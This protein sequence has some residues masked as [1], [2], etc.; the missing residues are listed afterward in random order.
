MSHS[1]INTRAFTLVE[2]IVVVGIITV[3]SAI[4]FQ[5]GNKFNDTIA[6]QSV[7]QDVS[8]A[9]REAQVNGTSVRDTTNTGNFTAGSGIVFDVSNPGYI[10]VFNDANG[11]GVYDGGTA[12]DGT[13]ECVDKIVLRSGVKILSVCGYN[14][15]PTPVCS[16]TFRTLQA[17][18]IRPSLSDTITITTTSGGFGAGGPW[19]GG[20]L[21]L[22]TPGGAQKMINIFTTGGV[23]IL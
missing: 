12:C 21:I 23:V 15:T 9:L 4:V 1:N 11:N 7:A 5:N 22:V 17:L 3:I 20:Q 8:L 14:G 10:M 13:D 2:L 16:R 18:F 19:I 6:L